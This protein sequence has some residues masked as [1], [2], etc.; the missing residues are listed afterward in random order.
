MAPA[1]AINT[2]NG[3]S[4]E[5]IGILDT[6]AD[7]TC[8]SVRLLRGLGID[9]DTLKS[10]NV[11]GTEG[12]A[13]ALDCSFIQ[14]GLMEF[15]A[16]RRHFPNGSAPVPLHFSSGPFCLFGQQSFLELCRVVFDGPN[17]AVLVDF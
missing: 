16:L 11:G 4:S 5:F 3:K 12:V 17:Q 7:Q 9:P 13:P 10:V 1:I 2:R 14:I 15:P 6:G 8:L